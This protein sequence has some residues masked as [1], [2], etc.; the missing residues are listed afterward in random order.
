MRFFIIGTAPIVLGA[1]ILVLGDRGKRVKQVKEKAECGNSKASVP[2]DA[3]VCP[4]C[5]AESA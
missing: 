4:A 1:I 3:Q 5:G 2:D